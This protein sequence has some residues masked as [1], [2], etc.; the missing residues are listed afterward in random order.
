[1]AQT[2]RCMSNLAA[3]LRCHHGSTQCVLC[4]YRFMLRFLGYISHA[5]GP[6]QSSA[7]YTC[8]THHELM[9]ALYHLPHHCL[10]NAQPGC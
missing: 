8:L 10:P 9:Q 5:V 4:I 7:V 3:L 2:S 1:M 6:G